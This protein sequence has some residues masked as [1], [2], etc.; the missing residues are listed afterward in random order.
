MY[1]WHAC[2]WVSDNDLVFCAGNHE[3]QNAIIAG[4]KKRELTM[5]WR[6]REIYERM[7]MK[8]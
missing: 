4:R 8:R 2:G 3:D 5:E 6:T 1:K 7:S